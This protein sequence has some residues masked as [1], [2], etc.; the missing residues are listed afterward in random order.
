MLTRYVVG[1]PRSRHDPVSSRV[2][3]SPDR[4]SVAAGVLCCRNVAFANDGQEYG[5]KATGPYQAR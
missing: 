3:D 1:V 5:T 2:M 4:P